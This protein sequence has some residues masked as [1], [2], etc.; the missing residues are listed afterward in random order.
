VWLVMLGQVGSVSS[1]P[2]GQAER[3]R[4][5]CFM[6]SMR[7]QVQGWDT[8]V[9]GTISKGHFVQGAQHPGTFGQGHIGRGHINP[10]SQHCSKAYS[11]HKHLHSSTFISSCRYC[12]TCKMRPLDERTL[13]ECAQNYE[14][15]TK[16]DSGTGITEMER[17]GVGKIG[18]RNVEYLPKVGGGKQDKRILEEKGNEDDIGKEFVER[19]FQCSK[20]PLGGATYTFPSVES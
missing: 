5:S 1:V 16:R 15:I 20:S 7:D 19:C 18:E 11:L 9:R 10:V 3:C 4:G 12:I 14:N 13:K 8:L 17:L 6:R 2:N